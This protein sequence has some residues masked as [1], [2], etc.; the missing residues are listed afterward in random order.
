MLGAVVRGLSWL[1]GKAMQ[2]LVWAFQGLYRMLDRM[3]T[4]LLRRS[5]YRRWLVLVLAAGTFAGALF[6]LPRLGYELIPQLSQ[7]E[8]VVEVRLPPG[9]PLA[10]TDAVI[11]RVQ[12]AAETLDGV[13]LTYSV[14]GTGNRLD[15]SP[16]DAGEHTGQLNVNLGEQ[17]TRLEEDRAMAT[18][19]RTLEE[20]PGVAYKFSRPALFSFARPLEVE[21]VGYD[22][23]RLAAVAEQVQRAMED[24]PRFA[25]VRSTVEAGNPE[26]QI[27]FD[28][29]RAARLG[30]VVRDIADTVVAKVR[31][32]IATRYTWRDKKIDVLVRTVDTRDSSLTEVENLIVNPA[33]DRPVP[34]K[35]VAEVRTALGPAEIRRADQERVAIISANIASGDLAGAAQTVRDILAATPMP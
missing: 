18:M 4:P 10:Q 27:I 28:H 7:G 22:L 15:A 13:A 33:S 35:A 16:V 3:Y 20:V 1:A 23:D 34:L 5:L 14:A 21:I 25:D 31:G 8:F 2:P 12:E 6:L 30:L 29:E 17:A 24:S 9:A 32:E 11:L 26:I 19:R